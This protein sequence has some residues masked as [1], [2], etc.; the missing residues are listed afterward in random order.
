[1]SKITLDWYTCKTEILQ[2]AS[3]SFEVIVDTES[4]VIF[5]QG[6]EFAQ[7]RKIFPRILTYDI[8]IMH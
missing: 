1:M 4:L 6:S 5:F 3:V 8:R 2:S 7:E